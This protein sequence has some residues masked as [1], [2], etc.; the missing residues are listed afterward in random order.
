MLT[1]IPGIKQTTVNGRVY[2]YHRATGKRIAVAPH[3]PAFVIEVARLNAEAGLGEVNT[4]FGGDSN[5]V[6]APGAPS[7][8][9]MLIAPN[10]RASP[11]APS[12]ITT[13]SSPI[14]PRST[15][16]R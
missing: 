5:T 9:L 8:S 15:R 7:P 13:A 10:M 12:R 1:K 2:Y 11:S 16:C 3:S 4:R 6:Q 14:S